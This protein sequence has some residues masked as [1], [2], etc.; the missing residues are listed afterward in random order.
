MQGTNQQGFYKFEMKINGNIPVFD[1]IKFNNYVHTYRYDR[2]GV[3]S[4]Y[5]TSIFN[6]GDKKH[7]IN[8]VEVLAFDE[9]PGCMNIGSSRMSVSEQRS[10]FLAKDE[11][12][13]LALKTEMQEKSKKLVKVC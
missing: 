1:S 13:N 6:V 4:G 12:L 3:M 7:K 8:V 2:L 10:N 9:V 11:V 5:Y